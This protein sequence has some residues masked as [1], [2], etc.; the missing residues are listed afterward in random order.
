LDFS[1]SRKMIRVEPGMLVGGVVDDQFGNYPQTAFMGLG[2]KALHIGEG[3]VVR[4][5]GFVRGDVVTIVAPWR[6]VER[7]QPEGIDPKLGDV[8]ELGDQA[9]EIT[10]A[11]VVRIE[12]GLDVHLVDDRVLV[13]QR[14]VDEVCRAGTLGHVRLLSVSAFTFASNLKLEA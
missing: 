3:A 8:V 12:E 10:D 13:P 6:G 1:V 11:V 5:H 9:G 2:D 14:V 4:V 7:Q